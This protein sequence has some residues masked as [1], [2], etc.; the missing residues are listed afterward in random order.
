MILAAIRFR[1]VKPELSWPG[2][3]GQ[4]FFGFRINP[5]AGGKRILPLFFSGRVWIMGGDSQGQGGSPLWGSHLRLMRT[6]K[7]GS[8]PCRNLT[9]GVRARTPLPTV[10]AT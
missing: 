10:T 8:C 7:D 6:H 3:E 9:F 5:R 2:E 1:C 4:G